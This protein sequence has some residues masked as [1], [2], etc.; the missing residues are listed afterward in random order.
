MSDEILLDSAKAWTEVYIDSPVLDIQQYIEKGFDVKQIQDGLGPMDDFQLSISQ[1]WDTS[2]DIELLVQHKNHWEELRVAELLESVPWLKYFAADG[3]NITDPLHALSLS[4]NRCTRLIQRL[5]SLL[6]NTII[7]SDWKVKALKIL[8]EWD[9]KHKRSRMLYFSST[10]VIHTIR[11]EKERKNNMIYVLWEQMQS[12]TSECAKHRDYQKFAKKVAEFCLEAGCPIVE[13]DPRSDVSALRRHLS[14]NL[15]AREAE[16]RE[17]IQELRNANRAQQRIITNLTF[18]HLLEM[19]PPPKDRLTSAT[20]QWE[21]FIYTALEKAQKQLSEEHMSHPLVPV[22]KKHNRLK[23]IKN[24]GKHLYATLSSNIHHFSGQFTVLSDQWNT[25]EADL[26]RA[27][28]PL[29][30]NCTEAGV[31]WEKERLRY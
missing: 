10:E 9:N 3:G 6:S 31:N 8:K 16:L 27:L 30:G 19:L 7:M 17:E 5:D 14:Q 12:S 11:L 4:A 15:S 26:L 29:P 25:L 21:S 24:V 22:L 13:H 28:V 23:Q 1:Y 18:R 2:P 20:S